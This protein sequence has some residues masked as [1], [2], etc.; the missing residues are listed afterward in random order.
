[1]QSDNQFNGT[2]EF[3]AYDRSENSTEKKDNVRVVVDNITPTAQVTYNEPVKNANG[4]SYYAGDINGTVVIN[5]ANFY[6]EDVQ[7]VVTR[8]GNVVP[9]SVAWIDN[10]VDQHTGTFTLHDDGDYIVTINYADRSSNKMTT[11][12]SNEL[13][14]DT[15]QPGVSVSN[16][17]MNSA[18]KDET[19]GFTITA[20][21][22]N[23]DS[24]T[25]KPVLTAV[26]RGED[27]SYTTKTIS[28]GDMATVQEGQT[29]SYT[30]NNLEEDGIYTLTCAVKDM[31]DN[32]Y[33][34]IRLDDGREYETVQFSINR[35]GS[36][37][38]IDEYTGE[39]NNQYY[40]YS[41][42]ND[43]VL[44]E[45]NA[46]PITNYNVVVNGR[47]LGSEE[48]TT[49]MT[50]GNGEW[51]KRTYTIPKSLFETEGE[52]NIVIRST[53]KTNTEAYSDV[54][55]VKVAFVV[56]QTAPVLTIS[57][58]EA[59]GRYQ[60]NEQTVTVI[61]T[62]DGGRL[63]SFKAIVYDNDGNPL[64]DENGKDISVRFEMEGE[65]LLKYLEEHDGKI[66]F[67]VPEGYQNN[68]QIICTDC[69][70]N[71]EGATNVFDETYTKVTVSA[72]QIVIFYANKPLFYGTVAG[73]VAVTGGIIFLIA[74][75]KRKKEQE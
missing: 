37:F 64:K 42:D 48:Y 10:S 72:S 41:V 32:A 44:V 56:D 15:V 61:P 40:I 16:I 24:A 13:T 2:I 63:Y 3:I 22:I 62:D 27:G 71:S 69:A 49:T 74:Y 38:A 54:K 46:D 36:T 6:S 11:Y 70:K 12:T 58:L 9:V 45:I 34:N 52:Y 17:K 18:N 29:Y 26:V 31:S 51:Y 67:T 50:G 75:K 21:D 47:V 57:G 55:N 66:T 8:D 68:V 43:I 73:I 28:L 39:V 5:E 33:A 25:F 1:M 53:D 23:F 14:V 59:D 60:T 7:V 19:Y 20:N 65:E 4:I 30:V 35:D